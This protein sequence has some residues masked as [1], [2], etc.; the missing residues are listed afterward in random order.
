MNKKQ[1][2]LWVMLV[3]HKTDSWGHKEVVGPAFPLSLFVSNKGLQK[4]IM[5][6]ENV[7]SLLSLYH[8]NK[9][10]IEKDP[11]LKQCFTEMKKMLKQQGK[12]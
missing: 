2:T 6:C 11:E 5:Q 9:E 7:E 10:R 4:L 8:D 1:Q 3:G 12:I